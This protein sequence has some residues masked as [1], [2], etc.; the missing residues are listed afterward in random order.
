MST[1]EMRL[2][3]KTPGLCGRQRSQCRHAA[4]PPIAIVLTHRDAAAD[5]AAERHHDVGAYCADCHRIT[6]TVASLA[7]AMPG[8]SAVNV[9]LRWLMVSQTTNAALLGRAQQ[10]ADPSPNCVQCL[11]V[12]AKAVQMRTNLQVKRLPCRLRF[13]RL[14]QRWWRDACRLVQVQPGESLRSQEGQCRPRP[15]YG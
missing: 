2:H 5:P 10:A 15:R 9:Q 1:I 13:V 8:L 6:W 14:H 3:S 11:T 4:R 12:H 7:D